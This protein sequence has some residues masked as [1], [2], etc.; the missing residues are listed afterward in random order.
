MLFR[1]GLTTADT[2]RLARN[3]I[4]DDGAV[5]ASDVPAVMKAKYQLLNRGGVL[6]FEYDTTQLA[7]LAGFRGLK[8]W[9]GQRAW[10]FQSDRPAE[11]DPPKGILLLGVQGCGKSLAA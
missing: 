6:S 2:E 7:D 8:H 10:A 1:S 3:A 5:T 11:L 9:L 4:R